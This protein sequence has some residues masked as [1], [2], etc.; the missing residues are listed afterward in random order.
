MRHLSSISCLVISAAFTAVLAAAAADDPLE[1]PR[2]QNR[3]V[4]DGDL[5]D[6]RGPA[7]R[8]VFDDPDLLPPLRNSGDFRLVWDAEHLWFGVAITDA[9]VYPPLPS[10]TGASVYQWDSIEIYVDGRGNRSE[11]MD[12][13]DTQ[14]IVACDGRYGTMQGDELLRSVE[15]WEV[16]KRERLG[17]AVR[18]A[19]RRT[20]TG[21]V[22]EGAFPLT[23]VD[24]AE[25]RAGHVIALDMGWNDWIEDHPRLPELLKDLENLA[26]LVHFDSEDSVEVVDPDSLGW[27]G[28]LDWE[29]RAYRPHSWCSG[30]D[31]G[32]PPRWGLVRLAGRPP[33]AEALV[34]RWGLG[35]LLGTVFVVLLGAAV[36]VDLRGRRRYRRRLRDLSRRLEEMPPQAPPSPDAGADWLE[37]VGDRLD[38]I[39]PGGDDAPD[40]VGRVLAHVRDHLA[41]SLS[42]GEVAA[43]VGV[44]PRTLQRTCQEELGAPPRDV[45]LAVKMRHAR[46]ALAS[47]RWR[48]REVA[49]QVGFDSPYHFSRRFKDVHGCPPSALIPPRSGA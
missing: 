40:T 20:P 29:E 30:P 21:Y 13:N 16:P 23:A 6:W 31:F 7:L 12:E 47:G 28:L 9:E 15:D 33:L 18:T 1:L 44:S 46:E 11:R 27:S 3:L 26:Q 49:E 35:P 2:R 48:V 17:L 38:G 22:V 5:A 8:V 42:V 43:G 24:L 32:H 45:I 25:P 19:A 34:E 36:A 14:L 39:D 10:A 37:R 41:E 4:I